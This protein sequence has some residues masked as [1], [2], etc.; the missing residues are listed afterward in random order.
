MD[1]DDRCSPVSLPHKVM[2][3]LDSDSLEPSLRERCEQ[4][5]TAETRRLAHAATITRWTPTNSSFVA[6]SP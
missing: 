6:G 2:T 1:G 5:F 3:S 4:L